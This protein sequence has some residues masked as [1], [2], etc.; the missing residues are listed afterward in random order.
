MEEELRAGT[1]LAGMTIR[2]K[3]GN[4]SFGITY[5]AEDNDSR[6]PYALK[7][8]FPAGHALRGPNRTV[9][10]Q[11][12]QTRTFERGLKSFFTEAGT[13]RSLPAVPGLVGVRGVFTRNG[14]AYCVMEFVDGE[15]LDRILERCERENR[16]IP[17]S[18]IVE[19]VLAIVDALETLHRARL[20]HRD[21]K[22]ANVMIRR[23]GGGP[24][25]IDFGAARRDDLPFDDFLMLTGQYAPIEQ[26]RLAWDAQAAQLREGPWTDI[27]AL[28]VMLYRMTAGERPPDA[29][30]RLRAL[31]HAGADCYVPLARKLRTVGRAGLYS[32][33]LTDLIDHGAALF[34]AQRPPDVQSFARPLRGSAVPPPS[35]RPARDDAPT[36][37]WTQPLAAPV[38]SLR[39][40]RRLWR[41]ILLIV[42]V[43]LAGIATDVLSGG[44]VSRAL[45][46]WFP[47]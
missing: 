26:M 19:F 14:T 9:A 40:Q 16:V 39:P 13:L 3:L 24:V 45:S 28:S 25:L 17:E 18:W 15:S 20:L 32:S 34:P 6:V 8:Y 37:V 7:E 46:E 31:R 12:A 21:I 2:R 27:F 1:V 35:T 4:G 30:T 10:A 44:A 42:F 23:I 43:G 29:E 47:R 11:P 36:R 38:P 33:V 22:P 5:L 41:W